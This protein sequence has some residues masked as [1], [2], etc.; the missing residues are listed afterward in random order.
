MHVTLIRG[1]L[2]LTLLTNYGNAIRDSGLDREIV[3]VNTLDRV[4][5]H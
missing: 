4:I 1:D 5:H 3:Y 2:G